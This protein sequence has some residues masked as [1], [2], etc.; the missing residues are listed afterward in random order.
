MCQHSSKN[1]NLIKISFVEYK[2]KRNHP[3]IFIDLR[4]RHVGKCHPELS[5]V[6]N[7]I[8]SLLSVTST[9]CGTSR[10]QTRKTTM[11]TACA[12]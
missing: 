6:I 3:P 12:S 2:L 7:V 4:S 11:Q 9:T 1:N 5:N 8:G 10:D